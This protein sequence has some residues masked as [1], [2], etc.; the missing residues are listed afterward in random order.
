MKRVI[1]SSSTAAAVTLKPGSKLPLSINFKLAEW[2]DKSEDYC[3]IHKTV[4]AESIF[5]GKKVVLVGVPAAFSGT[6]RPHLYV[7]SPSD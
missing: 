5:K 3:G 4:S 1:R 6:V 7:L 2:S